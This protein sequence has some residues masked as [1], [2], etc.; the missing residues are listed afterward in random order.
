MGLILALDRGNDSLK[1]ALFDSGTIELRWRLE[2]ERFEG[3]LRRLVLDAAFGTIVSG[4]ARLSPG[5][6]R[7]LV[8]IVADSAVL[9]GAVYCSVVPGSMKEISRALTRLGAGNIL[10]VNSGILFPFRIAVESPSKVGPDRLAAAAGV[11]AAGG[12]EG[13]IVDAG[14]AVTVD[15]L[16]KKGFLG[17]AIFPGKDLWYR[18]LHEGTAALPLV[19]DA[20]GTI[21]SPGRNTREA[22]LSGVRWGVVGAVKEL[23]ARSRRHVSKDA[24][25]WVTGGG[26]AGLARYLGPLARYE[27]DLV[28]LG[29][30]HLFEL[31]SR[32]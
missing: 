13:I 19:P 8:R 28:F 16:A 9:E 26:G 15:V 21:D 2:G 12:R 30:H 29:L 6:R 27:K 22:I 10:E 4:R 23:V 7:R 17:G 20:G 25:V 1:V 14:T 18:A 11:V 31:N 32:V 3:R 5:D 24:R